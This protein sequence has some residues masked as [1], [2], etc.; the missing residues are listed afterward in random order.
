MYANLKCHTYPSLSIRL[1]VPGGK[2][3]RWK[4]KRETDEAVFLS[5]LPLP[6]PHL[7]SPSPI[8]LGRPDTQAT[9]TQSYMLNEM[10]SFEYGDI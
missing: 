2:G 3:E 8:P 10:L 5:L 1:G 4:Q 9:L 6:L 7:K